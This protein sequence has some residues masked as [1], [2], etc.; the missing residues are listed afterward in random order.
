M[1]QMS[2]GPEIMKGDLT[3]KFQNGL[4]RTLKIAMR[5]FITSSLAILIGNH[6]S[7]T[8]WVTCLWMKCPLESVMFTTT[9]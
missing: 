6:L 8:I 3:K 5:K 2:I 1:T 7:I 9:K 4:V